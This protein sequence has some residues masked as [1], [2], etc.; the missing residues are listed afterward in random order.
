MQGGIEIAVAM[1]QNDPSEPIADNGLTVWDA[2]LS[3]TARWGDRASV[4]LA[5]IRKIK[6]GM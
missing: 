1:H 4:A 5:A 6:G 3:D 2:I